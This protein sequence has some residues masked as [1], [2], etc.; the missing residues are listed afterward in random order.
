[1]LGNFGFDRISKS[2]LRLLSTAKT[3]VR[4]MINVRN[5]DACSITGYILH[6]SDNDN[7]KV[8]VKIIGKLYVI[9]QARRK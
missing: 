9:I 2:L 4:I 5:H 8:Y 1:M 6:F 3:K 7:N